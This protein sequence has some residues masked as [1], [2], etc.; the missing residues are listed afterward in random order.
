MSADNASVLKQFTSNLVVAI[1]P[2]VAEHLPVREGVELLKSAALEYMLLER[3]MK[4]E[5]AAAA[6]NY[7]VKWVYKQ[8]KRMKSGLLLVEPARLAV[9]DF[10]ART[11]PGSATIAECATDLE[12]RRCFKSMTHLVDLVEVH[13]NLGYIERDGH[14]FRWRPSSVLSHDS[15]KLTSRVERASTLVLVAVRLLKQYVE[16]ER[17]DRMFFRLKGEIAR[18]AYEEM[19]EEIR[20]ATKTAMRRARERS[21][22]IAPDGVYEDTVAFDGLVLVD[23]SPP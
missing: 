3:G 8:L 14:R 6:L 19:I 15:T 12:K 22:E 13:C 4:K 2:V 16:S 11:H 9:L 7:S 17:T 10:F 23:L 5:Q 20:A 21:F 18:E 1:A